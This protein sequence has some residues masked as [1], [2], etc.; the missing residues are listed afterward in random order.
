MERHLFLSEESVISW[1]VIC[2]LIQIK[3]DSKRR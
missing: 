3:E 2:D 1:K